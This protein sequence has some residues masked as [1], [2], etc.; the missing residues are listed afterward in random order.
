[1]RSFPEVRNGIYPGLSAA[2]DF[3]AIEDLP[4]RRA[5]LI[6]TGFLG[7]RLR[8]AGQAMAKLQRGWP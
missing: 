7:L 5:R 4:P 6:L 8:A 2:T 1:M 3:F